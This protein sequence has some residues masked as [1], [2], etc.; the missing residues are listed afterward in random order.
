MIL[1]KWLSNGFDLTNY[2][3]VKV[4]QKGLDDGKAVK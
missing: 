2:D 1:N 4:V 3:D